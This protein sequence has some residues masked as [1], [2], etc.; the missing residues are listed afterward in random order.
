MPY[1]DPE[2]ARAHA[3]E[4]NKKR[5][6]NLSEEEKE[7]IR[8][9]KR[10]YRQRP[11]VKKQEQAYRKQYREKNLQKILDNYDPVKASKYYF[12]NRERLVKRRKEYYHE[13]QKKFLEY[14]KEYLKNPE[15]AKKVA[16]R[17]KKYWINN[18]DRL[19][20]YSRK[21]VIKVRKELRDSYMIQLL[22][23]DGC[24]TIT[25]DMIEVKRDILKIRRFIKQ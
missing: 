24:K 14:Q 9:R 20:E 2:K 6:A 16:K 25:P 18:H 21:H 7:I 1:K 19:K 8:A 10:A 11:E 12:D 23:S 17:M 13:N 3:R 22:K 15:N 4:Y 5:Y